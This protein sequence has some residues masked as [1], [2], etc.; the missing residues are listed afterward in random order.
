MSIIGPNGAGKSTLLKAL[1]GLVCV[2][3]GRVSLRGADVT[4]LRPDLR[5]RRGLNYV[6]QL[7][8]VFP[9]LTVAENLKLGVLGLPRAERRAALARVS[10]CSR[11][12]PSGRGS[13]RARSRAAAQARRARPGARYRPASCSCSTSP[14]PDSRRPRWTRVFE[15]LLEIN[16]L[17]IAIL[18][19]EQNARRA[20][21][22]STA[23]TCSTWAGTPT[24]GRAPSCCTTRRWSS[25]TWAGSRR[26]AP[27]ARPRRA[28]PAGSARRRSRSC[29]PGS[30]RRRPRGARR[31]RRASRQP[32]R[33]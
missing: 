29:S 32:A 12:S 27:R 14:R 11:S 6:P 20:L 30:H 31:R 7:A 10:S 3:A 17:G 25:S 22:I 21:A 4:H 8:N 16:R 19:V 5:T 15:Q 1:Y 33:G 24:R 9:S 28:H 2:R 13:V 18:M 23:G 26:R